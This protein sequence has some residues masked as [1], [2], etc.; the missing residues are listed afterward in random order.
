[1]PPTPY[2]CP[3]CAAQDEQAG[4]C[5]RGHGWL[6]DLSDPADRSELHAHLEVLRPGGEDW[7]HISEFLALELV[8]FVAVLAVSFAGDFDTYTALWTQGHIWGLLAGSAAVV[9]LFWGTRWGLG[10]R[11]LKARTFARLLAT[12]EANG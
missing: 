10:R 12:T 1:M 11:S 9:A 5:P 6:L 3:L 4:V 7:R 2:I 8:C